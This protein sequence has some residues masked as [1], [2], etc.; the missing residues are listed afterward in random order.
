VPQLYLHV[1]RAR[2][3]Q[4]ESSGEELGLTS[5]T[6]RLVCMSQGIVRIGEQGLGVAF[7][8]SVYGLLGPAKAVPCVVHDLEGSLRTGYRKAVRRRSGQRTCAASAARSLCLLSFHTR[9][10]A[11]AL[12]RTRSDALLKRSNF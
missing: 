12:R 4:L 2:G 8:P 3:L 6:T 1:S 5:M 7:G 11:T 10:K 9:E